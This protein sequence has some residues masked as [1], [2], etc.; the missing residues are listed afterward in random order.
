MI[1]GLPANKGCVN[2]LDG[3]AFDKHQTMATAMRGNEGIL[4]PI[5]VMVEGGTQPWLDMR[6]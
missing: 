6:T 3:P 1:Y 4:F 2:D 5:V